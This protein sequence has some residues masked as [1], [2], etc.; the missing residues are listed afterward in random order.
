MADDVVDPS[1]RPLPDVIAGRYRIVSR[2]GV[3]GMGIVY[4]AIDLQLNR[5]VAVKALE[6]RRLLLPGAA[7]RL[8]A[9]ALAAASFD[10]PYVC[11]VYELAET[12]TETFMIM[13]YV[14]GETLASLLKRGVPPLLQTL[15][16]VREIAEG[17]AS[18]HARGL[19]HRDVK[20]ANVMVMP[21]GHVKLLDFGVAGMDVESLSGEDTRTQ[22]PLQTRLHAGTPHYMAPEQAAGQP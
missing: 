15:Q 3:G 2:L 9:E 8:R 17:L 11:K 6:D 19:V 7:S 14:E 20:P 1:P 22:L 21:N 4:K 13:E 10:H 16:F 12:P 5:A 18:A